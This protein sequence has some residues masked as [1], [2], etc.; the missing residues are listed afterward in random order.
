M[1]GNRVTLQRNP[2]QIM[3]L[4]KINSILISVFDKE[5]LAELLP[6]FQQH[7]VKI[8]STGGTYTFI[9]DKGFDAIEVEEITSFPSILGGRV[10]TLHPGVFGGILAR[11]ANEKDQQELAQYHIPEIDAVMVDLY[12]FEATVASTDDESTIIEKIDIGGV[13]LI[14]A[15]AKNHKDVLIIPSKRQYSF[16]HHVMFNQSASTTLAD[17]Q[18]MARAAFAETTHY[19]GAI[20]NWMMRDES[21]RYG[22]NPH[23]KAIFNGKLDQ[24]FDQLNGKA[25]SYNNLLD[26]DAA[27]NLIIE[28]ATPTVAILK[29]NNACGIASADNGLTAWEKALA[30]DPVAAF[31]GVVIS[32]VAID[33]AMAQAIHPIFLEVLIAPGYSEAA[34]TLLKEKKNRI[35]LL[36]KEIYVPQARQRRSILNGS[37]EQDYDSFMVDIR[38][39]QSATGVDASEAQLADLQFANK[40]VKH[41]KSNAIALVKDQQLIGSGCGQTSRVDALQGAINK[42]K[43]FNFDLSGAVMASDAFFPFPDCVEIADK[44]GITAVIQPGGSLKDQAS[45]DYCREHKI[46]MYM[47]GYRHFRH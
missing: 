19:D 16:L 1:R 46:A 45:I 14:R 41:L 28:F 8:Y 29:H 15:A 40:V 36:Q 5:G 27:M 39:L 10:K 47:S 37:L 26:I 23:Q 12:P 43:Q 32:N 35:I 31:G 4:K 9:K 13:S 44:A 38:G 22:E 33:E 6:A 42:A 2:S 7:N 25:I 17:R 3:D 24:L 21:L 11:R 30:G 20:R 34:L 18:A